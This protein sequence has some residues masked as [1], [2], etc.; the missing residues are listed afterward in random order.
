MYE[1]VELSSLV[2]TN[3]IRCI[4]DLSVPFRWKK[5]SQHSAAHHSPCTSRDISSK[6]ESASFADR[7][8]VTR[9]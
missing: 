9:V 8:S 3:G 4:N 5:H 1:R 2:M 7:E 6:Y